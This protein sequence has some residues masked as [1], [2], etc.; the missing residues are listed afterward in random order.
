MLTGTER[1]GCPSQICDRTVLI[2]RNRDD[3]KNNVLGEVGLRENEFFYPLHF[4]SRK[5]VLNFIDQY[6]GAYFYT[7]NT[8]KSLITLAKINH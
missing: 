1:F 7:N 6:N 5:A 4:L 8:V 2:S 3:S